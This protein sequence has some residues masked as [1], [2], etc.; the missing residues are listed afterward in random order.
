[1]RK[2]AE[3][4]DRRADVRAA[5]RSW[6][7]AGVIDRN[8]MEAIVSEY[9]D[10]R[11]RVGPAFRVLLFL[12]TLVAAGAAFAL[13]V[14]NDA[15]MG[16]LL[17]FSALAS[18]ALTEIQIGTM[19]RSGAGSEEA[20]ALLSLGFS[21]ATL[22]WTFDRMGAGVAWRLLLLATALLAAAAAWRWGMSVFGAI[23]A[24]CLFPL[25]DSRAGWILLAAVLAPPLVA[26]SVAPV[27]APSQR[28]SADA[29]LVV[30][31]VG[32][33][34]A[35]HLGSY[36]VWLIERGTS[37]LGL[38]PHAAHA[39]ESSG[40]WGRPLFAAA[41][42]L[43]PVV[44]LVAGIR[45]RRPLLL[46][47]GLV[48]GVASLVTLRFYVHLAPLWVILTVSGGLAIVAGLLLHRHLRSGRAGERY[49]FTA[50]PL[51]G[52]GSGAGALE[53]GLSASLA[54]GAS[55]PPGGPGFR[56]GGGEFGGGGAT[57]SY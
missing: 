56:G 30:A 24:A 39:G 17:S 44:V 11:S 19:R 9:A 2:D 55:P 26:L 41:T 5:A 16:G 33:Y 8:A 35:V 1:M 27:L 47:M 40:R 13:F 57:G 48:L 50:E 21:F 23:S 25:F 22:V 4:A 6:Q 32:L 18:I 28:R 45:W 53:V 15:P 34:V 14:I 20:T 10:D 46:R 49:G 7:R 43:V 42:A 36:D 12:F 31:L 37:F 54:P 51:F 38:H 3:E 52:S 29:A